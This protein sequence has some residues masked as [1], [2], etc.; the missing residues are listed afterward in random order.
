MTHHI[1]AYGLKNAFVENFHATLLPFSLCVVNFFWRHK[2][3]A[4]W[5]QRDPRVLDLFDF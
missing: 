3:F 1:T 4:V 5:L 2:T